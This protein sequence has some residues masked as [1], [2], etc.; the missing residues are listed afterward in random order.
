MNSFLYGIKELIK[1]NLEKGM[2]LREALINVGF[3]QIEGTN[4]YV[5]GYGLYEDKVLITV[6]PN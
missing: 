4:T 3:H 1:K 2:T 5:M 6:I